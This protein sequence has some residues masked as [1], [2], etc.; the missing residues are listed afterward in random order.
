MPDADKL[1]RLDPAS[2]EIVER[3]GITLGALVIERYQASDEQE[4]NSPVN[5]T[6]GSLLLL[7]V[8][9]ARNGVLGVLDRV[10][11]GPGEGSRLEA[12]GSA[13][14]GRWLFVSI[15]N[16]GGEKGTFARIETVTD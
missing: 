15:S 12:I 3:G 7:D 8:S 10:P 6:N 14:D 9:D 2:C 13:E 16:G 4:T 1:P 11:V 5:E